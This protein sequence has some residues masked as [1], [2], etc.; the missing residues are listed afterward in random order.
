MRSPQLLPLR[1]RFPLLLLA[2][3]TA[4]L[5]VTRGATDL[6][7]L[8]E[9]L[10]THLP[11][12]TAEELSAPSEEALLQQLAPR[13]RWADPNRAAEP[14]PTPP[15]RRRH[16][17]DFGYV[18]LSA[19]KG[20]VA[21]QLGDA[22]A[23]LGRDG[24]VRGLVLDLRF[25][26][27]RDF[28]A[29]A[30][31]ADLLLPAG[32]PMLDWGSGM[33]TSGRSNAFRAPLVV[34]ANRDTRGSAEALAA[35]LRSAGRTVMIG[36]RT[37]GDAVDFKEVPLASGRTL[38]LALHSVKTGDGRPI[39]TDGLAPDVPVPHSTGAE[40]HFL[41]NPF[42][43]APAPGNGPDVPASQ[44]LAA[45]TQV[46]RRVTEAELIRS[47]RQ[48]LGQQEPEPEPSPVVPTPAE[49]PVLDPVLQRGLD[50]LTAL[51]AVAP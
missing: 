23:S 30:K 41:D 43:V 49:P 3:L 42:T 15:V 44:E 51:N 47:K 2:V 27:G 28:A 37:A 14:E 46:R 24:P 12:V 9:A 22:L 33:T 5:C 19:V 29:A 1:R 6:E 48:S 35:I 16:P 34:L 8:R 18:R 39:S 11:S 20:E 21:S 4:E 50:L 36:G 40:R 13:V 32:E 7:E 31:T 10:R 25:S 26:G 17:G 45:A 38:Q